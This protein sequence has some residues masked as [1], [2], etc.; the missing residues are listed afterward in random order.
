MNAEIQACS[1]GDQGT[2]KSH[3]APSGVVEVNGQDFAARALGGAIDQGSPIVVTAGDI[4][5]LVVRELTAKTDPKSLPNFGHAAYGSFGDR[6]K[7]KA[8]EE[9]KDRQASLAAWRK[10]ARF[11]QLQFGLIFGIAAIWLLDPVMITAEHSLA[12]RIGYGLTFFVVAAIWAV[13]V[14]RCIDSVTRQFDEEFIRLISLS[15]LIA[16]G[17][18]AFGLWAI[19]SQGIWTGLGLAVIGTIAGALIIPL[20]AATFLAE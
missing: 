15:T 16:L 7:A 20:G 19:Q 2:A 3:L 11:R 9:E 17:G 8:A 12:S 13:A 5:G 1:V 10:T 14:F 4:G 6:T 18:S